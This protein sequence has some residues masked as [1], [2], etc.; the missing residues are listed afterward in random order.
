MTVFLKLKTLIKLSNL[1]HKRILDD[2]LAQ[3]S[4]NLDNTVLDRL[5]T[6]SSG[7]L[8]ASDNLV[9]AMY[10]PQ[11]SSVIALHLGNYLKVLRPLQDTLLRQQEQSLVDQF[12]TLS[13]SGQ[14]GDKTV[15]WFTLSFDQI[16]KAAE[17][18]SGT[19]MENTYTQVS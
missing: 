19:L 9:T 1:L 18:I 16:E 15:R 4:P 8:V 11:Q 17:K 3:N 6:H 12:A 14:C 2:L 13:V 5:A 7:L 10:A